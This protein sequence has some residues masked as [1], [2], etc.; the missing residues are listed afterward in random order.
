[1]YSALQTSCST[2][3]LASTGDDKI[4]KDEDSSAVTKAKEKKG[5]MP[6]DTSSAPFYDTK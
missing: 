1:M 5:S 2:K 4:Y 6:F 3:K